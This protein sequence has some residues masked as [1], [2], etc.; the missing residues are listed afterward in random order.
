LRKEAQASTQAPPSALVEVQK[1]IAAA[2][3]AYW[4]TELTVLDHATMT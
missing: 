2:G 3:G 1:A 4:F